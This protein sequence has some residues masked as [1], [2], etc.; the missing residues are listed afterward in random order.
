MEGKLGYNVTELLRRDDW[1]FGRTLTYKLIDKGLL[2]ARKCGK[3][4]IIMH[5]DAE[6]C[7]ANLPDYQ[8]R[9]AQG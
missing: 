6:A 9:E 1:P 7:L 8:P 2:K 4:T 3:S 5:R